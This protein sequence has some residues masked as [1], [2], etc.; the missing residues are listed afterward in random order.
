MD[1]RAIKPEDNKGGTLTQELAAEEVTTAYVTPVPTEAPG[2]LWMKPG[3]VEEEA[4]YFKSKDAGGGTVGGLIRDYTNLNGGV[5]RLHQNGANYEILQSALTVGN[6]IDILKEGF[7]REQATVARVD[8]DT[9]TVAGNVAL[10]YSTGRLLRLNSDNNEIMTVLSSSYD[11]MTQLTTV[12]VDGAIP[13]PLTVLEYGVQPKTA[14]YVTPSGTS[15]LTNKTLVDPLMRT[16]DDETLPWKTITLTPGF[17]KPTTTGGCA[18]SEKLE[19]GTNDIDFDALAFDAS[20]DERA[21]ANFQM[22]NSWNGGAIQFRYIWSNAS[23]LTTETVEFELKGRA[24]ADSDAIDQATGSAVAVSD[25]WLAQ[26]DIHISGWSADVTLAGS[27]AGGQWVHIEIMRDVS[28]DNL[29][30]DARLIAVQIRYK[31]AAIT[32]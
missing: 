32:D 29:T 19:A 27:P 11:G 17:L 7:I 18:D 23:G 25:T 1:T 31:Q 24:Y 10:V 20:T 9:L 8:A 15:V 22:P 30:G 21:Y 2:V 16:V 6:I 14:S 28:D 4:I 5:G 13:D 26:N 3:T 12:E